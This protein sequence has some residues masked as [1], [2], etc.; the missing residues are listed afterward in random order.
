MNL[1]MTRSLYILTT[2]I[3]FPLLSPPSDSDFESQLT[4]GNDLNAG[5]NFLKNILRALQV[6]QNSVGY[7]VAHKTLQNWD[8][9][10]AW[11]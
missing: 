5:M 1:L 6:A 7:V 10:A 4:L 11:P 3:Q 9:V 2:F 8:P